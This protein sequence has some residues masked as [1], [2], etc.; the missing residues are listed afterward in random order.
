MM[1]YEIHSGFNSN[2]KTQSKKG[3]SGL[4]LKLKNLKLKKPIFRLCFS[5]NLS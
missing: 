2:R 5:I 1:Q 4:D 3:V